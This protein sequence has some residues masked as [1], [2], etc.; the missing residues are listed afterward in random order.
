[1]RGEFINEYRS[2]RKIKKRFVAGF[3]LIR[4]LERYC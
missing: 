3:G 4:L 2:I 1:M